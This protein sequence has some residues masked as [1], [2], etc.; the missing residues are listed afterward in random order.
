MRLLSSSSR[1][2]RSCG[3]VCRPGKDVCQHKI[4]MTLAQGCRAVP[5]SPYLVKQFP[6]YLVRC[7]YL[8]KPHE[9]TCGEVGLLH[10]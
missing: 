6:I 7:V 5:A 9:C 2:C 3:S 1:R 4:Q 10:H 8:L